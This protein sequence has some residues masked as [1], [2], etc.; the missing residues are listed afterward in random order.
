VASQ[1]TTSLRSRLEAAFDEAVIVGGGEVF[2]R[3]FR[4]AGHVIGLRCA[5]S[6][7]FTDLTRPLAHVVD[8]GPEEAELTVLAW[9]ATGGVGFPVEPFSETPSPWRRGNHF[10]QFEPSD[11]GPDRTTAQRWRRISGLVHDDLGVF[12]AS[13][14]S[15]IPLHDRGAPLLSPLHRWLSHKGF[16]VAHAGA[17]ATGAAAVLIVGGGGAGKSTT[18][19]ASSNRGLLFLGDDY[20][21]TEPEA[22]RV[23]SLYCSAKLGW[24]YSARIASGIEP[25]NR[26][27]SSSEDPESDEKALF[28]LR[29]RAV[30][31]AT[32]AAVVVPKVDPESR[33]ELV[34]LPAGK[35][36]AAM[37]PSNVF[38]LPHDSART[39]ADLRQIC[40]ALP[41]YELRIGHDHERIGGLL[42]GILP[43]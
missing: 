1:L 15:A 20:V 13:G 38:Q 43:S 39:L 23:H 29:D 5:G 33:C 27:P 25:V 16:R 42:V 7:L 8:T 18:A 19:V 30:T 2:E 28:I 12:W 6:E 36:L 3:R 32:L 11:A 4:V 22:L 37:A 26:R 9:D 41:A 21:V 34:P 14:A 10:L 31:S 24:G 17:V 35:A 40:A